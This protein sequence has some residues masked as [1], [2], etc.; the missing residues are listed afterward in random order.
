MYHTPYLS[1]V[2]PPHLHEY[3]ADLWLRL[4][5]DIYG[6]QMANDPTV[7]YYAISLDS[8]IC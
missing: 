8:F 4:H 5:V 6:L 1:S 3:L 2:E 7:S